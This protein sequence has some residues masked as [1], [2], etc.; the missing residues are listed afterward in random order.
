MFEPHP[1]ADARKRSAVA[2][3]KYLLAN[4]NPEILDEHRCE[5]L[6]RVL[7]FKITEAESPKFET[8]FRS[9]EA[10]NCDKTKIKLRHDHVYQR[11]KMVA[12]LKQAEPD[13]VDRILAKAVGCTVTEEEHSR[14]SKF[15]EYDGWARYQKA[16]IVVIDT[17]TNV[18][19]LY[20]D[21]PL[22]RR[23]HVPRHQS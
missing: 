12:E 19:F 15:K 5:L 4:K 9:Q 22:P 3:V 14:L 6:R 10:L 18:P 21:L 17:K 8:R 16:E 20:N 23:P 13:E 2:L 11:S 1:D 7:L